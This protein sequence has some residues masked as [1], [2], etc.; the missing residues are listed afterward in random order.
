VGLDACLERMRTLRA[1]EYVCEACLATKPVQELARLGRN[2]R[3]IV[4]AGRVL[5][6][7]LP[8]DTDAQPRSVLAALMLP[9]LYAGR[10]DEARDAHRRAYRLFRDD[11]E[12]LTAH[13]TF[14]ALTGNEARGLE[15]FSSHLDELGITPKG[16]RD[17]ELMAAAA[18]L[19][20]R[21]IAVGRGEETFIWPADP[22]DPEDFEEEWTFAGL[23]EE[24]RDDALGM[25][26]RFDE[27]NGSGYT[28]ERIRGLMDAEPICDYLPLSPLAARRPADPTP[29]TVDASAPGAAA[30]ARADLPDEPDALLDAA[31]YALAVLDAQR[32]VD[33][34][35][36]LDPLIEEREIDRLVV[37]RRAD[38]RGTMRLP[39]VNAEAELREAAELFAALGQEAGAQVSLGRL[40]RWLCDHER[41][42]EGRPLLTASLAY[43]S[44]S[45]DPRMHAEAEV[46]LAKVLSEAGD[47]DGALAGLD[48]AAKLAAGLPV[49]LPVQVL[50]AKIDEERA[51]CLARS[52]ADR[53]A[54]AAEAARRARTA[55][56]TAG[57]PPHLAGMCML[58]A[59]LALELGDAE[60]ATEAYREA[61]RLAGVDAEAAAVARAHLGGLALDAGRAAE[62][63]P[64][65]VEAVAAF[66]AL[67]SP[68]SAHA[69]VTLAGAYQRVDRPL[70]AAEC[71]EE[72][73]PAV[74][75]EEDDGDAAMQA[76]WTLVCAYPR[77]NQHGDALKMVDEML[78]RVTDPEQTGRLHKEAGDILSGAD[79]DGEAAERFAAA[80][81]AFAAA[82]E[83]FVEAECRRVAALALSFADEP[84][85]AVVRL[86]Q[87]Q[88]VVDRLPTGSRRA[89]W[90][91]AMLGYDA[92]RILAN[93]GRHDEAVERARGAVEGFRMIGDEE[94]AEMAEQMLTALVE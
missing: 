71:A 88:E 89:S 51:R 12:E 10:V 34:L 6:G 54:E 70:D 2:A 46:R 56:R 40:G 24:Y 13:L 66:T 80:A 86:A 1:A 72:A 48:R 47:Q 55:Y 67:G 94:S 57:L 29:S 4:A 69:R 33:A 58:H 93:A 41:A 85:E 78:A 64:D 18:L 74:A 43:L 20:R 30:A 31:E 21:L 53:R 17:A 83:V 9:Y 63:I 52:G 82:G 77:L 87:A 11:G 35:E 15:I 50:G 5:S 68:L 19:L 49:S 73:L 22:D 92:G 79:R 27:R 44:A 26:A 75:A 42:E 32:V 81:D 60:S 36:R 62:A 3:A 16:L 8:C 59:G 84:E 45:G 39:G 14:C 90:E 61:A 28:A 25:A 23:Y 76:R 38:L 37:A 65:L 7:E 91:R